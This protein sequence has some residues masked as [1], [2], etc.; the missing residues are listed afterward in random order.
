MTSSE[1]EPDDRALD[2]MLEAVARHDAPRTLAARVSQAIDGNRSGAVAR[3]R[4]GFAIATA[5]AAALVIVVVAVWT[6]SRHPATPAPALESRHAPAATPGAATPSSATVPRSPEEPVAITLPARAARVAPRHGSPQDDH[7]RALPALDALPAV[8][9]PDI[10]PPSL[11]TTSIDIDP[12]NAIAPLT[13][14]SGRDTS[15][16]GDF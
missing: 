12:M 7:D 2:G 8:R 3:R 5:T 15:G 11:D 1:H 16:R 14:Q 6:P 13:V 9:Q 4:A 10:A